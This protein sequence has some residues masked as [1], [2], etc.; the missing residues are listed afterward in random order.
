LRSRAAVCLQEQISNAGAPSAPAWR[1]TSPRTKLSVISPTFNEAPNLAKLF[2]EICHAVEDLDYE[3]LI[4][5]D[6]SPDLTWKL[7]EEA[8]KS[9]PNIRVLRRTSA[10]GLSQAVIE[11]FRHAR[12]E[13][14]A[15]IDADLQ[16][17]PRILRDMLAALEGGADIVVGSRN[18]TGGGVSS[19]WN[20]F[21][22]IASWLATQAAKLAI[23]VPMTDPMSG[24]FAMRRESFL[25]AQDQFNV[26]GFKI[27]LEVLAKLKPKT[28]KEVPY[29]FRPRFAGRSKLS[30]L[31]VTQY[32][33]Q[34][35]RLSRT[36]RSVRPGSRDL[37]SVTAPEATSAQQ[38]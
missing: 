29:I 32:V 14:V 30:T 26:E 37:K 35:W 22:R 4:I 3:I 13:F 23:G 7:V 24:F 25:K 15:C 38:L 33:M 36:D 21:R 8:G 27:V 11:G 34:L 20:W 19:D 9:N 17:D 2:G 12:G 31:V 28:I 1:Y 18:I 6:D 5:D 16:H 10:R